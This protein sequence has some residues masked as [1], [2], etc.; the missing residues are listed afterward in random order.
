[1]NKLSFGLLSLI[2]TKPQSG[3]D[4]LLKF[5]RFWHTT[6]ST[7]YPL[8]SQL[9]EAEYISCDVMEQSGKPDKKIYTIT[10]KGFDKLVDW[11]YKPAGPAVIKDEMMLKLSCIQV[12]DQKTA[13]WLLDEMETRYQKQLSEYSETLAR[14]KSSGTSEKD[15]RES[16]DF[17][18]YILLSKVVSD[19]KSGIEWCNWVRDL[20]S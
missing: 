16:E 17:G 18:M 15:L 8:L 19:A 10:E 13:N 6:H 12:L 11:M 5:K 4:L 7:I 1:M 20:L 14:M 3:Y 9:L 2:S